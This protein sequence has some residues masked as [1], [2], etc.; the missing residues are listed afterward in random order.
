MYQYHYFCKKVPILYTRRSKF[1]CI[2]VPEGSSR[3]PE[4]K[5]TYYSIGWNM[6]VA[7]RFKPTVDAEIFE[8]RKKH[9]NWDEDFEIKDMDDNND[10]K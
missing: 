7:Y 1:E 4:F 6:F 3:I 5:K 10:K 8:L 9:I 2:R